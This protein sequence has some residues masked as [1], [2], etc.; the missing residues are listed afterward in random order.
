MR[1]PSSNRI[2]SLTMENI[3]DSVLAEGLASKAELNTLIDELYQFS[4]NPRTVA[5]LP[6]IV[7][8]WGYWPQA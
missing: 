2:H 5:N 3:V 4:R 1:R 7:Q 8:A 6:R